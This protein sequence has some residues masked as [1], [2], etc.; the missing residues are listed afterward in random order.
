MNASKAL[1]FLF[2]TIDAGGNVAPVMT[3]VA[4][5]IARGHRVR[6]MSDL[7]SRPETEA[8]GA[9]FVSWKRAPSKPDRSPECELMRDWDAETPQDAM[10]AVIDLICGQALGY[11]EDV[12]EELDREAAD[13]VVNFDM[14]FGVMTGCEARGQKLALLSTMLSMFPIPGIP[15]LGP[16][17]PPAKTEAER[18]LLAEIAAGAEALFDTGLPALNAARAALGLKPL[19]HV[20]DQAN[21]AAIRL[22]GTARAFDFPAEKLPE[23]TR[24]I[25]PLIRDPEW[26]ERWVS[27]WSASDERPLVLVSFST[28]FQ[29]HTAVLQRIID[30]CSELNVRVLVTLGGS[31]KPEELRPAPNS[32]LVKSAPHNAVMPQATL[33]VTHG[34][35]GTVS[36]GLVHRL[37]MLVIPH[38]RDQADNAVR[39]TERGAGL[40]F[41]AFASTEEIRA[42]IKCLLDEPSFRAAARKLG[43]AVAAEVANSRVVEELEDAAKSVTPD[44]S[45]SRVEGETAHA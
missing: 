39:I 44:I 6:V 35:H 10:L 12:I 42:A 25:G 38:G 5:L 17:L 13:L 7:A 24:Y 18:T 1:N 37:P 32:V 19:A 30:A 2:T 14:V 11:A 4:K 23:H 9:R 36:T 45:R 26:A 15:A 28:G 33:L 31:I 21:Y 34:G 40:S 29:N 20:Y 3:V 8:A 16:G 22:L 27:R 43:D 41:R